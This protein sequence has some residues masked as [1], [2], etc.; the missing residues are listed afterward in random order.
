MEC[1]GCGEQSDGCCCEYCGDYGGDHDHSHEGG[2]EH[3]RALCDECWAREVHPTG[4]CG[5][6]CDCE[7]RFSEVAGE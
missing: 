1:D 5:F 3:S 7:E 4:G 6:E 2:D